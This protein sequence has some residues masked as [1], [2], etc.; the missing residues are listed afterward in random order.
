[1]K[2][3]RVKF[4]ILFVFLF[5]FSLAEENYVKDKII[6][7]FK[8]L[9]GKL[10]TYA[11][12]NSLENIPSSV[13]K[14]LAANNA[15][16]INTL[17]IAKTGALKTMSNIGAAQLTKLQ[18][19][20]SSFGLDR[21]CVVEFSTTQDIQFL[22]A[23]LKDDDNVE[24]VQ[25]SYIYRLLVWPNDP[26]TPNQYHLA[27]VRAPTGWDVGTGSATIKIA[28][29]DTGISMDHEDLSGK[30]VN[31]YD[32][33][34]GDTS[35]D[36]GHG[37]GTRVSGIAAGIAN[38]GKGIAG[39]DW[40]ARIMPLKVFDNSGAN[41]DTTK[42][43]NAINWARGY[44]AS[45]INMSLGSTSSDKTME[46]ACNTAYSSGILITAAAGNDYSSVINYPAGFDSV[47]GVGAV[48]SSDYHASFSNTNTSVELCAPG[49]EIYSTTLTGYG[50][51]ASGTGT[52]FSSPMVAGLCGLM[53]AAHGDL[54]NDTIRVVLHNAA[55]DLGETGYDTSYGYGRINIYNSL[56]LASS[57]TSRSNSSLQD[58]YNFPNPVTDSSTKFS[59]K[60]EKQ[61]TSA[62]FMIYDLKGRLI[63][64]LE[65]GSGATNGTYV[66][67]S[68]DCTD[69]RG[70]K[71]PNGTYIYAVEA[72][73]EDGGTSRGRGKLSIVN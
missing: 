6:I 37:H 47:I 58:I 36:D 28:V 35:P 16:S 15:I 10:T 57:Y 69:D 73:K 64:T 11:N 8:Q 17:G 39:I 48:N 63:T 54:D 30:I 72:E 70:N 13:K 9:S 29:I 52:S 49:V 50:A 2:N 12:Y 23:Q 42:I 61:I 45:V 18:E 67:G 4:F 1:M 46:T 65:S 32:F 5:A 71:L 44:G 31:P 20:D 24:Y 66:T 60:S 43:V 59:F 38:N 14:I 51:T 40:Q 27:Q 25:P 56:R 68:W 21:T 41:A 7:K 22:I 33:Y 34:Y 53:K 19:I 26:A 55:D 62:K 3:I